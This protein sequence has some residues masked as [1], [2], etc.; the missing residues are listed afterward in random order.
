[1]FICDISVLNKY[2][3]ALLDDILRPL[4]SDWRELVVLFVI[5]QVPGITQS[6]LTPFLQTDKANVSKFLQ[7]MERKDL[8]RRD[9]ADA[10]QRNKACYLTASG[11]AQLPALHDA[12]ERWEATCFKNVGPEDRKQFE[13]ISNILTQNLTGGRF[14]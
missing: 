14:L 9:A 13:R 4:K 7:E 8:I 3:K 2:G 12:I 11:Q 1:M 5:E 10:D 6:R